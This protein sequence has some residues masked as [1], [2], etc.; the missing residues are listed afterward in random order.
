[1]C[2]GRREQESPPSCIQS[3]YV[4]IDDTTPSTTTSSTPSTTTTTTTTATQQ[5]PSVIF[6]IHHLYN[7]HN[8]FNLV[9]CCTRSNCLYLMGSLLYVCLALWD[10]R[11][12]QS[13]YDVTDNDDDDGNTVDDTVIMNTTSFSSWNTIT[14]TTT[15]EYMNTTT[16][17]D[18]LT[19]YHHSHHVS[20]PIWSF[21]RMVYHQMDL[22]LLLS[23]LAASC[24]VIDAGLCLM[25]TFRCVTP[26]SSSSSSSSPQ[27]VLDDSTDGTFVHRFQSSHSYSTTTTTTSR[28]RLFY[29]SLTFG[30]GAMLDL[31][32]AGTTEM[33]QYSYLSTCAVVGAAHF[34]LVHAL[35]VL[36]HPWSRFITTTST[37]TLNTNTDSITK[38]P[39]RMLSSSSITAIADGLFLM[40]S[41]V[42]VSLS[43]FY[44]GEHYDAN[45]TVWVYI[46]RGYLF[47]SIL[48]LLNAILY[49]SA[50]ICIDSDT[51]QHNHIPPNH[52]LCR[53]GH[54]DDTSIRPPILESTTV[55]VST[56][57]QRQGKSKRFELR[58]YHNQNDPHGNVDPVSLLLDH[59]LCL[60]DVTRIEVPPQPPPLPDDTARATTYNTTA[61]SFI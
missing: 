24:Y 51:S 7:K 48:W 45:I 11:N 25:Q 59:S 35:L 34:Y 55:V 22:Y 40:G 14:T 1:M 47:S 58:F 4:T 53:A 23:I 54:N 50:D 29:I 26:S 28:T 6:P 27:M 8:S 10:I 20:F 46:Y 17:D 18:N 36:S 37:S 5:D 42:D 56:K 12:E 9:R 61:S 3:P 43:Y 31:L 21:F 16:T 60:H 38:L 41:M 33:E 19:Q 52:H 49:I 15:T 39:F 13:W 2:A 30:M 57:P 32:A 44:L